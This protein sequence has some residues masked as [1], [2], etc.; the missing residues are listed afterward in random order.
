MGKREEAL[1]AAQKA[2]KAYGDLATK[3]PDAYGPDLAMSLNNLANLLSAVGK[4]EEALEAAQK[5]VKMR[6]E[7]ATKN[8]D[9]YGA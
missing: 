9:A 2:V 8:P 1:E 6:K 3:N 5:A 4:R 7:L